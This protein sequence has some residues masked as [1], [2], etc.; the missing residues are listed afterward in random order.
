MIITGTTVII[1]NS[2]NNEY[3]N[4]NKIMIMMK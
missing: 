4:M 3:A 2:E 1:K